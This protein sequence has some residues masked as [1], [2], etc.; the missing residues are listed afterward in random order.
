MKARLEQTTIKL[1]QPNE[2]PFEIFDTDLTGFMLRVQPTG[3]R[4]YYYCYRN[5]GI[6]RR[7]R[8]GQH[9]QLTPVSARK[10]AEK[11]AA[12]VALGTDVQ[13]EK[14]EALAKASK[15]KL[16]TL[17]NFIEN[18]YQPWREVE[19]KDGKAEIERLKLHFEPWYEKQLSA[20]NTW[21]LSKWRKQRLMA[22]INPK[23]VNRDIACLKTALSYAVKIDLITDNPLSKLKPIKVDDREK[24]RFLSED[25]EKALRDQLD[26]REQGARTKRINA[27]K[28]RKEREYNSFR[29]ISANEFTDYVKPIVLL[30]M[31]TGCRPSEILSL[32]WE[33]VSFK[34]KLLTVEGALTKSGKTR[35]IPLSNEALGVLIQWRNQ[36]NGKG[37]V[38]PS[39]QS[40]EVM[41]KLPR[42]I[43]RSIRLAGL[44]E[45]RPYDLRHSFASRLAMS[46]VDLNT[47]RELLGHADISTTLI[48]AHLSENHKKQAISSVFDGE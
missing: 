19:K 44:R 39:P 32:S 30:M 8:I 4:T 18:E 6:M 42:A 10:A 26:E 9:G 43:T 48:Y 17:K 25:E 37:L 16:L 12:K 34:H 24:V 28:W 11:L 35:H 45:F 13:L 46:G 33:N 21:L 40:G 41:D 38:F 20:I 5:T 7:L 2:K 3:V 23:T 27:N 14:T 31:N 29:E 47:I 1:L 36:K 15:D 22:G